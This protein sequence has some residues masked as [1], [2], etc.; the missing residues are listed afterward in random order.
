MNF[1]WDYYATSDRVLHVDGR[2][3]SFRVREWSP[4]W[5]YVLDGESPIMTTVHTVGTIHGRVRRFKS[6]E[7]AEEAA[8]AEWTYQRDMAARKAKEVP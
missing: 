7:R 1:T 4:G 3:T 8:I 6:I 2:V 5:W